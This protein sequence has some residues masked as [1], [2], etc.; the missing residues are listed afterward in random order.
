MNARIETRRRP[1]SLAVSAQ[2]DA[3]LERNALGAAM[4]G[5]SYPRWLKP[6]HFFATQHGII[7]EAVQT[8][9]AGPHRVNE[10]LRA[11]SGQWSAQVATS[12]EL[13]EMCLE[14]DHARRMGWAIDWDRLRE[15]AKRREL[16]AAM[17]R[18]EVGF[19]HD[20]MSVREARAELSRVFQETK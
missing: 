7:F 2:Y 4:L 20:G 5:E 12:V 19:E 6:G 3:E 15:L 10:W 13:A 9:G 11:R 8:V 18:V 17:R 16:L 14:A 1:L